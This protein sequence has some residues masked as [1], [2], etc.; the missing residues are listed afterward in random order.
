MSTEQAVLYYS[1]DAANAVRHSRSSFEAKPAIYQIL[2]LLTFRNL[3]CNHLRVNKDSCI[4]RTI[5]CG[6]EVVEKTSSGEVI[7]DSQIECLD[8]QTG[9]TL[10]EIYEH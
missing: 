4:C 6:E 1:E 10:Q 5:N 2:L 8:L 7:G 3:Q 9:P